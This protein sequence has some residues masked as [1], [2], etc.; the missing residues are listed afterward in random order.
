MSTKVHASLGPSTGLDL[1]NTPSLLSSASLATFTPNPSLDVSCPSSNSTPDIDT[2]DTAALYDPASLPPLPPPP[3][4]EIE[5]L[6][7]N[8]PNYLATIH[9]HT[10]SPSGTLTQEAYSTPVSRKSVLLSLEYF[11]ALRKHLTP[12]LSTLHLYPNTALATACNSPTRRSPTLTA[13]ETAQHASAMHHIDINECLRAIH[14]DWNCHAFGLPDIMGAAADVRRDRNFFAHAFPT[15]SGKGVWMEWVVRGKKEVYSRL[16]GVV[17]SGIRRLEE[18]LGRKG[19]WVS[20]VVL[21]RE[22]VEREAREKGGDG[23]DGWKGDAAQEEDRCCGQDEDVDWMEQ[24]RST[25]SRVFDCLG[26]NVVFSTFFRIS[27][28]RRA[29][30]SVL[31]WLGEMLAEA[32]TAAQ[33][34]SEEEMAEGYSEGSEEDAEEENEVGDCSTGDEKIY[35]SQG[36]DVE[37]KETDGGWGDAQW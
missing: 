26:G 10:L 35:E 8:Y 14:S 17:E 6:D 22:R 18:Q 7:P 9:Y 34:R 23:A 27:S 11:Y 20:P 24:S 3:Q 33:I 2:T 29:G 19:C 13:L 30:W 4:D 16:L 37:G 36:E 28:V 12:N 15:P 31:S 1:T 5:T 21:E 32:D 25:F